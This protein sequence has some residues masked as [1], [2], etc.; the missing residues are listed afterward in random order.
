VNAFG[1]LA[2]YG[3]I[4]LTIL[5]FLLLPPRRAVFVSLLGGWLFLP[6]ASIPVAGFPDL[7]KFTAMSVGPFIASVL[8]DSGRIASYRPRWF[9][10]PILVFCLSPLFSALSVGLGPYEGFSAVL[11]FVVT[12][13]LPYLLGRLYLTDRTALGE[14]LVALCV[15]A[16]VYLPLTAYEMRMSPQLHTRVYGFNQHVF[17]QTARFGGWRPLVFLQHGL[18]LSLFMAT[19]A[20]GAMGLWM[21]GTRKRMLF[22]TARAC[23]GILVVTVVLCRSV[24]AFMLMVVGAAVLWASR[25]GK[26]AWPVLLVFAF[27]VF[28]MVFRFSGVL[29]TRVIVELFGDLVDADRTQSLEYRLVAEDILLDKGKERLLLG[30]GP[31]GQF[32]TTEDGRDLVGATDGFWVI[33][34]GQFGL[35]GLISYLGTVLLPAVRMLRT[36]GGVRSSE[37]PGVVVVTLGVLIGVHVVDLIL[38]AHP[39]PLYLLIAG[40]LAGASASTS[41]AAEV[42]SLP[43]APPASGRGPAP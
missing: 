41:T 37:N 36:R 1:Y 29:E 25:R 15:A 24:G 17:S 28:V 18:A 39:T 11:R 23:T 20:L 16:L 8:F 2:L 5:V 40:G 35:V 3:W 27:A 34:F 31:T 7:S 19:A 13:G 42:R 14:V 4:P 21:T 6:M 26:R 33:I 22:L 9:D 30:W 43:A 32:R 38:N 12:F 10:A